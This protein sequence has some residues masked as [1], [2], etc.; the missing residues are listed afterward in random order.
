MRFQ[1]KGQ[2]TITFFWCPTHS[3][4]LRWWLWYIYIYNYIYIYV[5]SGHMKTKMSKLKTDPAKSSKPF[6]LHNYA[7]EI[8]WIQWLHPPQKCPKASSFSWTAGIQPL[9]DGCGQDAPW[10]SVGWFFDILKNSIDLA[11]FFW[12]GCSKDTGETSWRL[13]GEHHSQSSQPQLRLWL[14]TDFGQGSM[15]ESPRFKQTGCKFRITW[16]TEKS[17]KTWC[18]SNVFLGGLTR[19]H[20]SKIVFMFSSPQIYDSTLTV[21]LFRLATLASV[22]H[23]FVSK[24]NG[25]TTEIP[26]ALFSCCSAVPDTTAEEVEKKRWMKDAEMGPMKF[27][28]S[29]CFWDLWHFMNLWDL[30][31]NMGQNPKDQIIQIALIKRG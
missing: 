27:R 8:A 4:G 28:S 17:L 7:L 26:M 3:K 29:T 15:V 19:F 18:G 9:A 31:S 21:E 1:D 12:G 22:S 10:F 2:L 30:M 6:R 5:A 20:S 13:F 25:K 11:A 16:S 23:I 24:T 14:D